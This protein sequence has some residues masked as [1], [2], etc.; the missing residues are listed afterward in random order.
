MKHN[1]DNTEQKPLSWRFRIGFSL[2]ILGFFSPLCIPLV[3]AT[4]LSTAWKTTLSGLFM[5]GI[6]ELFWLVAAAIMGKPGFN[7]IKKKVFGTLKR[8]A[9]PDKVSRTRYR[10][11]LVMLVIPLL[12]GW[13]EPYASPLIPGY[14]KHHVVL[15]IAGDVILFAS[16]FVLGGE[17]WDKLRTLFI[18]E[19]KVRI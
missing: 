1:A 6:P 7:Y 13:L 15:A 11:G 12:Y 2:F 16:L 14:E 10:L 17:F 4:N 9:L 5:L 3:T 18:Y 8:H 19:A